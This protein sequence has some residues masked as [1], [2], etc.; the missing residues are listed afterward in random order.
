MTSDWDRSASAWLSAMAEGGDWARR[1]VLDAVM[2]ERVRGSGSRALDVGCGEGRFCRLLA[3]E[4]IE[5]TGVDPTEAFIDAARRNDPG[6]RYSVGRAEH[7]PFPDGAFDLVLSYLSLVDIENL[8]AA[9]AEMTRVLGPGG[10][11]L[12]ANLASHNSAGR[13]LKDDRGEAVGFLID[14]YLQQRPIRQTWDGIDIVNWHRPLATYM[15]LFLRQ[16][17]RLSYFDE[18]EPKEDSGS[19]AR[20]FVRAPWFVVMEWLKEG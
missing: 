2:L 20:R 1:S 7:L 6:G 18:P 8:A 12:I 11:L 3:R 5:A 19:A 14:D 4:G 15:Q 9:A 17:L 10:K 13:W 16:G